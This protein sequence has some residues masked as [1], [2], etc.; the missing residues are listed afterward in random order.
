MSKG[1]KIAL[2]ALACTLVIGTIIVIISLNSTDDIQDY[3]L[4]EDVIKSVAT[5]VG[6]R[7][8][9]DTSISTQN[10]GTTRTVTYQSSTVHDDLIAY[11]QYLRT[12]GGFVVLGDGDFVELGKPSVEQGHIIIMTINYDYHEY[13]ITIQKG[14]GE[15][16]FE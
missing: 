15:F 9:T 8:V 1:S 11:T 2:I 12:D 13:T 4:G 3:I 14:V 5:I 10:N 7:D 16:Y 6:K